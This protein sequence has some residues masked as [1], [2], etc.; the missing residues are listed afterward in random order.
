MGE[1]CRSAHSQVRH[2]SRPTSSPTVDAPARP[3]TTRTYVSPRPIAALTASIVLAD[4]PRREFS[5]L[6]AGGPAGRDASAPSLVVTSRLILDAQRVPVSS[7]RFA[8]RVSRLAFRIPHSAFRIPRFAFLIAPQCSCSTL[9]RTLDGLERMI[10][11]RFEGRLPTRSPGPACR[12]C[13]I[14]SE[15]RDGRAWLDADQ[16]APDR[17]P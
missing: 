1:P 13:S 4:L 2:G 9:R 7:S 6:V 16:T 5:R 14:R 3:T 12:W 15:C 11:I 8:S 17:R 10:E